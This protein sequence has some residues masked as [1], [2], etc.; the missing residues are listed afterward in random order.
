MCDSTSQHESSRSRHVCCL[1]KCD[2]VHKMCKSKYIP[3]L[4]F[5]SITMLTYIE[6]HS[7]TLRHTVTDVSMSLQDKAIG[8]KNALFLLSVD[9]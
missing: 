8:E 3:I 4:L 9:V 6:Q 7:R 5:P 2:C 1:G